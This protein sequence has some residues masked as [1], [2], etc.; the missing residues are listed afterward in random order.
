MARFSID[1]SYRQVCVFLADQ[2]NPF[3]DW[4]E[5]H[6]AQGFAWRPGSVSFRT[7]DDGSLAVSVMINR[8]FDE[9]S[10]ATRVIRVP[11]SV[12]TGSTVEVGSMFDSQQIDLAAGE[13]ALTFEH[14]RSPDGTMWCELFFEP[15]AHAVQASVLR[16][17]QEL[18]PG[19]QLLMNAEPA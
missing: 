10:T 18:R 13:Y 5:Q 11:F 7:L 12:S 19:E 1:V 6:V 9:A 3:N 8:R 2:H 15:V 17:D 4:T 16:A 14:G